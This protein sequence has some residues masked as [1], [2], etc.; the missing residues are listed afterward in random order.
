M[1]NSEVTSAFQSTWVN[2]HIYGSWGSFSNLKTRE[3]DTETMRTNCAFEFFKSEMVDFSDGAP[4]GNP[5]DI[6]LGFMKFQI[7]KFLFRILKLYDDLIWNRAMIEFF[8]GIFTKSRLVLKI[9]ADT[10]FGSQH[11]HQSECKWLG[12]VFPMG[13]AD[14][15]DIAPLLTVW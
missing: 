1:L 2:H 6:S 12:M 14:C 8:L 3:C 10:L 4:I 9:E 13:I 11:G 7:P 5:I 15:G